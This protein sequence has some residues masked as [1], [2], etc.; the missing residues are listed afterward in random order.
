[1]LG[2][3]GSVADHAGDVG[4]RGI[5]VGGNC[6]ACAGAGGSFEGSVGVG[7]VGVG[8]AMGAHAGGIALGGG[9]VADN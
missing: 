8:S 2:L 7:S 6:P 4:V 5:I 3:S 9:I 1:M